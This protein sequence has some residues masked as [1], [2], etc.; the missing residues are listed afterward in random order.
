MKIE[1]LYFEGC[2]NS[3]PTYHNLLEALKDL[4]IDIPVDKINVSTLEMA[5]KT[6]FMGSPS[7]Y[8]DGID[9]YTEKY[10]DNISYSCR[11][12]NIDNQITGILPKS[13]IS[14]KLKNFLSKF[15]SN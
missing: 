14:Q 12:Y 6:K 10:P 3:E 13:F 5:Q 8:V 15:L 4:N 1:F 7:I 2:P 11:T 9:I